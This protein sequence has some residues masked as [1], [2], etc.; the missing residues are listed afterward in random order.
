M[1]LVL[2][3]QTE[4]HH[5]ACIAASGVAIPVTFED[6]LNRDAELT[7]RVVVTVSPA[8]RLRIGPPILSALASWP[9][10]LCAVC[11]DQDLRIMSGSPYASVGERFHYERNAN[12]NVISLFTGGMK[13]WPIDDY[14]ARDRVL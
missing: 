10:A 5:R 7:V 4:H 11:M 1:V 3:A 8:Q 9:G 13:A 2:F 12:G 6:L 14:R